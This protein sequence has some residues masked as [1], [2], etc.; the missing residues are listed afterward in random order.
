MAVLNMTDQMTALEIVRRANAP[1]PFHIIEL[2]RLTNEMLIDVPAYEANNATVNV[3]LQRNI[4]QMGEHR[5]YNQ[6]VGRV[7]TQTTLVKDR[8]AMIGAYCNIDAAM[9][10][11]SGNKSAAM[12]SEASAIIKGMGLTQAHTLIYGD[13]NKP[14]EFDGLMVRLNKL[15]DKNV[16]DAGGTGSDN[17][18]IYLVAVG[19]DMFHLLYPKGSTSVGVKREDRGLVDVPDPDHPGKEYPVYKNYFTAQYGMTVIMPDAVKR[20]CNIPP[21]ISGDDLLDL[22]IDA[23]YRLPQGASTY[24]MYS[25][26]EPLI[27]L[28]KAARDKGNVVYTAADPWGNPITHVRDMRCRRMDVIVSTEARVV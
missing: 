2:M 26:I 23:R 1:D 16:I 28:D 8:I 11:H 14:E 7:A 18:S 25:N 12:M 22:I 19:R 20:I 9:L 27:K 3:A 17:T 6:G 24:V 21:N 13:G 5:I 10:E 15:S 4:G